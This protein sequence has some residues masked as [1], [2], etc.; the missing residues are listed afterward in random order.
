MENPFSWDYLTAPLSETHFGPLSVAFAVFFTLVFVGSI[1]NP[2]LRN[3]IHSGSQILIW[4]TAAGL[5]FYAFRLMRVPFLNLYMRI[6]IYLAFLLL[7][8][9]VVY[10]V[11][12]MR[13]VY[14]IKLAAYQK[15]RERRRYTA[16]A[17]S[18]AR[19]RGRKTRP[20]RTA[21]KSR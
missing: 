18:A 21:A 17:Q 8:L 9:A 3:A 1:V 6:W 2:L 5:F 12:Y 19:S 20:R 16:P 11:Y 10:F 13:K 4:I 15:R 14:P 7:V